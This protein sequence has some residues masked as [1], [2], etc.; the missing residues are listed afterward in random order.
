MLH[1]FLLGFMHKSLIKAQSKIILNELV[2]LI[3]NNNKS[4]Y[5]LSIII[6]IFTST[7]ISKNRR[8]SLQLDW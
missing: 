8:F 3:Q 4:L 1:L 5:I 6:F 2:L 7:I